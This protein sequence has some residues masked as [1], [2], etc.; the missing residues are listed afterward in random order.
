LVLD[1]SSP[2]EFR[3][4]PSQLTP[5]KYVP[6]QLRTKMKFQHEIF[7]HSATLRLPFSFFLEEWLVHDSD[8]RLARFPVVG[9]DQNGG[10]PQT[11]GE[12]AVL[13]RG[14]FTSVYVLG[15]RV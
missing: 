11:A 15:S 3:T 12:N 2:S 1:G 4:A 14:T 8:H 6:F 9:A 7:R 5:Q 13:V 10:A